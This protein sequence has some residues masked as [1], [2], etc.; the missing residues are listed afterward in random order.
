MTDERE[1]YARGDWNVIDHRSGF[2]KK[3]SEVV[4]ESPGVVVSRE[5]YDPP[6]PQDFV[7]ARRDR[8][9]VV[10]P[11]PEGEDCFH[12]SVDPNTLLPVGLLLTEEGGRLLI[13][14][15]GFLR[16]E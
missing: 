8:Q 15:G 7:R 1:H 4:R 10:V 5:N 16:L 6:H 2:K 3:A 14:G 13:E 9:G 12:S 11:R